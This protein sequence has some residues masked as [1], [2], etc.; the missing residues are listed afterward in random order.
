MVREKIFLTPEQTKRLEALKDDIAW[1]SEEIR[2]A[3]YVGLDVTD[4]KTRFNKMQ[5]VRERM[6]EE[7]GRK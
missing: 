7:Y 4:L 3:E 6:L 5:T 2:R 1:L